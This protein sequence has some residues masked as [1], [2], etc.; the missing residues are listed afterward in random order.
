MEVSASLGAFG[1]Q[2]SGAFLPLVDAFLAFL[3]EEPLLRAIQLF[4]LG[5]ASLLVFFVF[6]T[7]RDILHRTTSLLYQVSC[8]LLVAALPVAGFLL[9]LLIRPSRTL[10]EREMQ[11]NLRRIL[12]RL[13]KPLSPRPHLPSLPLRHAR[14]LRIAASQPPSVQAESKREGAQ[15]F[16]RRPVPTTAST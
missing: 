9:Y 2:A 7:T 4:L 6:F 14:P 5:G 13:E 15:E 3:S 12:E 16:K 11:E 1:E 10:K 8:I